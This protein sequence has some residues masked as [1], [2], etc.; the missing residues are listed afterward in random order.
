MDQ[1]VEV[2]VSTLGAP[3]SSQMPAPEEEFQQ[4]EMDES[5]PMI[6][7]EHPTSLQIDTDKSKKPADSSPFTPTQDQ[8]WPSNYNKSSEQKRNTSQTDD[9]APQAENRTSQSYTRTLRTDNHVAQNDNRSEVDSKATFDLYSPRSQNTPMA[10]ESVDKTRSKRRKLDDD[11][12][13]QNINDE[14]LGSD[15]DGEYVAGTPESE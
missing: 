11:P 12:E 13:E 7:K 10:I 15:S 8:P 3:E 14:R 9:R 5:Q 6:H 2:V 4:C 1:C